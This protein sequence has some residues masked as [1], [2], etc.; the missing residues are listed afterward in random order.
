M[1]RS[2]FKELPLPCAFLDEVALERN[3]QSIIKL[4]GHKKIRIASK[5]LRSV[6][7]MKKIL[8]TNDCFQGIMCFSPREALFLIEQGFNDLLLGYPAYNERALYEISLLTKQGFIITCMVDCE[9][10]IVYLEKI[11]EKSSGCFRVCLDI[12]MSSRF[13]RFHFGVRRS[14]VKDVQNALKIVEKVKAS[15]YLILDGVMGYEAQIAGVGDDM[16]K[17]WLQNKLISYL[18]RKSVLEINKRRGNIVKEIQ[19]LGVELRFVNGGG[20]GSIK[21]TEQDNSV[22]EITVGSAFYSPKLFDYYKEVKFQPAVGFA[23]QVVRKPDRYIYT[24]LGGG[25]IASGAVGKDKEPEVW[26]PDGAKLLALEG[27]GEVQTPVYYNGDEQ[28]YIG[29][30][31][32]LR[33]SKAGELCERF[34]VLYRIKQG[35]IVGEY[36]TYR[37]DNQCFL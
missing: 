16:P 15:P 4:S 5:S 18:K 17:Q 22:T 33:H 34:P 7:I 10:H 6:S 30:T 9:E 28:L 24:C 37:G 13:F 21:S 27:A 19:N 1:D 29:D 35:E 12:D 14:P 26:K 32:L 31:I 11:A 25:Y 8:A 23:L 20:T 2:I 36:S 3:I